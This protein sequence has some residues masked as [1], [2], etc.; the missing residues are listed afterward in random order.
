[1]PPSDSARTSPVAP[2]DIIAGKYVVTGV[3]ASGGMGVV[4]SARDKHLDR[5]VAIK[6]LREGMAA[7]D[8]VLARFEREGR[9]IA[10]LTGEHIA[11]VFDFGRLASGEP[12]FVMEL[13][14]GETVG[15]RC[16][17]IGKLPVTEAV[18]FL[19]QT[20][21][22]LAEAHATGIVH[23]D[24]KP[25][26]LFIAKRLDGTE[27]IKIIDF[28]ISKVRENLGHVTVG[29]D[30]IGTPAYMAP[31]QLE[32]PQGVDERADIWSLGAVLYKL[33]SGRLPFAAEGVLQIVSAIAQSDPTPLASVEAGLPAGLCAAVD[34][35]LR[36]DVAERFASVV[37]LA[38]ALTPYS[39][40]SEA[41]GVARIERLERITRGRSMAAIKV[42]GKSPDETPTTAEPSAAVI[43][44]PTTGP[45]PTPTSASGQTTDSPPKPSRRNALA[46]GLTATAVAGVALLARAWGSRGD[47]RAPMPSGAPLPQP[48]P[49]TTSSAPSGPPIRIGVLHSLTGTMASSESSLVDAVLLAIAQVNAGGGLLGRPVEAVVKDGRSEADTFVEQA[50]HLLD[51]EHVPVVFG[52]WTSTSRR[53]VRSLFEARGIPLF[54]SVQ[55]EGIEASPA[56]IYLG[57]APNQQLIPAVRWAFAFLARKRFF[58]VGS[59]YVFPRVAVEILKD[60]LGVLGATV[61]GEAFLPLGATDVSAVVAQVKKSGATMILNTI[62]GDTN[63][64]FIRALRAAGVTSEAVPMLSFSLD[65]TGYRELDPK[66]VA[67]DYLAWNYFEAFESPANKDFLAKLHERFGPRPAT[68]PMATSYS[69]VLLWAEMVRRAGS[70]ELGAIRGVLD[71]VTVSTP[72]GELRISPEN[73]HA[74][75]TVAIGQIGADGSVQVVWSVP[76]PVEATPYPETRSREEWEKLLVKLQRE[77]GGKW[78][79][80]AAP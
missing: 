36:R 8:G 50:R 52:C 65:R 73:G 26:N 10:A 64:A 24:L 44:R 9:L 79:A 33:L 34:R 23:R 66:L 13:L 37:E 48:I 11:K 71:K 27:T 51:D 70:L 42:G 69:A 31:E 45:A 12:F 56:I 54:Y 1:M 46:L 17:R 62:N 15:E 78:Q 5:L 32:A 72:L 57:A 49:S 68:D 3:L 74:V 59:D 41:T 21:E 22:G 39:A 47:E 4:V 30:M 6:L 75:K 63:L 55:Y 38:S 60:Q 40:T 76:K 2:G 43:A 16:R 58:L 35:C 67:N 18:N 61:A 20:C 19:L 29:S 25:D 7:R 80:P 14:E 77:W 28:G 53:A